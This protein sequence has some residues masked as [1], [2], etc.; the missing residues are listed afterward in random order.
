MNLALSPPANGFPITNGNEVDDDI[1]MSV[2]TTA[3]FASG[4][5]LPPPEIKCKC[6]SPFANNLYSTN[7][8]ENPAVIDRTAP[9]V[10]KHADPALFEDKIR[11]NKRSDPH[12]SFLNPA[13]PYHAYYRYR[14][15]KVAQGETGD[16]STVEKDGKL[17]L[18]EEHAAPVDVGVEPPI[19]EYIMDM[20]NISS[21]DL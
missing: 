15:A 17:D 6:Y 5:I 13:D 18:D 1:D 16:G 21:I 10:S 12:F 8:Y 19:P 4:M 7:P 14:M 2:A 3:R 9:F 11:E 20:P